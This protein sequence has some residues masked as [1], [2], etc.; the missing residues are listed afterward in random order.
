L[1]AAKEIVESVH[2]DPHQ[3][4]TAVLIALGDLD[5]WS[6]DGDFD[7]AR[8]LY[9]AALAMDT[10]LGHQPN[11]ARDHNRIGYLEFSD[12]HDEKASQALQAAI[13]VASKIP[14]SASPL[15]TAQYQHDYAGVLYET[16]DFDG[17]YTRYSDAKQQFST[18][19]GPD[20][21]EVASVENNLAR[22]CIERGRIDEARTLLVHAV[23]VQETKFGAEFHDLA[24]SLNNLALID[25]VDGKLVE[26]RLKLQR[27]VR[28]A[29]A[30]KLHIGAQSLIHQ[31]E[32]S[33]AESKPAEAKNYLDQAATILER[34]QIDG[35]RRAVYDSAL[36]E[37]NVR[38]CNFEAAGKLFAT[39]A[40]ALNVRWQ[41]TENVFT[42]ADRRRRQSLQKALANSRACM[43]S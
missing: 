18:V 11:V 30:H 39:T 37:L 23:L 20:S 21:G 16:G 8:E 5:A 15:L 9:A 35:W 1:S 10:K 22:I 24:F 31:A 36:A 34:H 13:D 33:L 26:A 40:P 27:A 19:Y 28:I 2:T 32:I 6:P 43:P 4:R 14:D 42:Q 17:A 38:R 25:M 29:T 3:D 7:K 12:G 41:A